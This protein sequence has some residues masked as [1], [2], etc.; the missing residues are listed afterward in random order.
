MKNMIT[1]TMVL[2]IAVSVSPFSQGQ[3]FTASSGSAAAGGSVNI[4]ATLDNT[5]EG[6]IQGWSFGLC[7]DSATATISTILEEQS[8]GFD[9]NQTSIYPDGWTQGVV[10]SFTGS[11]PIES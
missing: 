7:H 4:T 1:F 2:W 6:P 10:I 3:D 9:F 11:N 8:A 5:G